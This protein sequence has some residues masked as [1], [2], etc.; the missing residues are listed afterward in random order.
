MQ[1][2]QN[3]KTKSHFSSTKHIFLSYTPLTHSYNYTY[4]YNKETKVSHVG[5]VKE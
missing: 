4:L 5:E 3:H 2:K 1:N